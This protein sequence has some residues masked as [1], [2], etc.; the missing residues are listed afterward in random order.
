MVLKI[1]KDVLNRDEAA[2]G[3]EHLHSTSSTNVKFLY[4]VSTGL[5][6]LSYRIDCKSTPTPHG[7]LQNREH[8]RIDNNM[9][10]H[11]HLSDSMNWHLSDLLESINDTYL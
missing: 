7:L 4:V 10:V 2:T 8:S 5:R 6:L 1:N 9:H 11:I 3:S